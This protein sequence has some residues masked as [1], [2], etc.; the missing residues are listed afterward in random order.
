MIQSAHRRIS[1]QNLAETAVTGCRTGEFALSAS[2]DSGP[3][4]VL[5]QTGRSSRP[6]PE[7]GAAGP[8]K[9]TVFWANAVKFCQ[10][11]SLACVEPDKVAR[12][13]P[14]PCSSAIPA[15]R[16]QM[17]RTSQEA[18][19][20]PNPL[21]FQLKC[22][23]LAKNP[24]LPSWFEHMPQTATP[25]GF[26]MIIQRYQALNPPKC[27]KIRQQVHENPQYCRNSTTAPQPHA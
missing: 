16:S 1:A 15:Q 14:L 11:P 20:V 9:S 17:N 24:P 26:T 7:A 5:G 25:A 8:E 3:G 21:N 12:I 27:H 18:S 19:Q 23:K 2:V 22:S 13:L 10:K 6:K 4:K